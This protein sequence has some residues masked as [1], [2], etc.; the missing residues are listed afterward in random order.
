MGFVSCVANF[1]D[2]KSKNLL[3]TCNWLTLAI[4]IKLLWLLY[5]KLFS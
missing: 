2:K 5:A 3:F 1:N 4:I